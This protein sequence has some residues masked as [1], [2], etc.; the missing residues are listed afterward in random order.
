MLQTSKA[1]RSPQKKRKQT[2]H[3]NE[4]P[5]TQASLTVQAFMRAGTSTRTKMSKGPVR[6]RWISSLRVARFWTRVRPIS[7]RFTRKRSPRPGTPPNPSPPHF[8]ASRDSTRTEGAGAAARAERPGG[9]LPCSY[10]YLRSLSWTSRTFYFLDSRDL[11][12]VLRGLSWQ[13][14]RP[15]GRESLPCPHV[16]DLGKL[17]FCSQELTFAHIRSCPCRVCY[18]VV[19]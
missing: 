16:R 10:Y 7:S 19:A 17:V 8:G 3:E 18:G 14:E 6:S 15:L 1:M 9:D 11:L 4:V 13:R 5:H 2:K 12:E